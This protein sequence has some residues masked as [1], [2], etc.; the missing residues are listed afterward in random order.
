[1]RP[2]PA[3]SVVAV[4]VALG[5]ACAGEPGPTLGPAPVAP[6]TAPSTAPPQ[7]TDVQLAIRRGLASVQSF[8][9]D[10]TVVRAG[11]PGDVRVTVERT[12]AGLLKELHLAP[13]E[14]AYFGDPREGWEVTYSPP[15][16]DG[17]RGSA[18]RETNIPVGRASPPPSI[19]HTR[20]DPLDLAREVLGWEEARVSREEVGGRAVWVVQGST[21]NRIPELRIVTIDDQ[22]G[23]AL[24]YDAVQAGQPQ[25]HVRVENLATNLDADPSYAVPAGTPVSTIDVGHVRMTL[26]QARRATG[27]APLVPAWVP[28]G[29]SA[30]EVAATAGQ[31]RGP[32]LIAAAFRRGMDVLVVNVFLRPSG[33]SVPPMTAGTRPG[34]RF[35]PEGNLTAPLRVEQVRLSAGAL[36]G[37]DAE[38][39][40]GDTTGLS[41][42]TATLTVSVVGDVTSEEI[43]RVAESLQAAP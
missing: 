16:P 3:S 32:S 20:A 29:F 37:V 17:G 25:Y 5:P 39:R 6:S 15:T 34:D 1:M 14:H 31:A 30:A 22:T 24:R 38:R 4:L 12:A 42:H 23:L 35:D 13:S 28:A 40:V 33:P 36:A 10:V 11:S 8:R 18:L 41:A 9:A 19:E 27:F 43:T 2:G 26:E 21:P 7:L